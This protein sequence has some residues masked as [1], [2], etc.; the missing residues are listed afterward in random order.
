MSTFTKDARE[1]TDKVSHRVELVAGA[2]LAALMLRHGVGV[3]AEATVT[4]HRLDQDSFQ[5]PRPLTG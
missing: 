3:Q 2:R 5:A 1:T 4:P